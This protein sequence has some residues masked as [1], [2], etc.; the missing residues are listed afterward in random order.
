MRRIG[1]IPA[2]LIGIV[3]LPVV[4]QPKKNIDT[5]FQIGVFDGISNEFGSHMPKNPTAFVRG[6]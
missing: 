4:A 2:T 6:A 1:V 3:S 5:I